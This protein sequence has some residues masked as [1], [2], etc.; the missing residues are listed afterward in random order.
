MVP[1]DA[2]VVKT[3]TKAVLLLVEVIRFGQFS[4]EPTPIPRERST[5]E[6][7]FDRGRQPRWGVLRDTSKDSFATLTQIRPQEGQQ[8]D[9]Y[10]VFDLQRN[11]RSGTPVVTVTNRGSECSVSLAKQSAFLDLFG[12]SGGKSFLFRL[13]PLRSLNLRS[14]TRFDEATAQLHSKRIPRR[15]VGDDECP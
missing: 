5:G 10:L 6:Q 15:R 7:F 2:V 1:P 8:L 11:L 9:D 14:I 13:M 4:E 12:G 3:G